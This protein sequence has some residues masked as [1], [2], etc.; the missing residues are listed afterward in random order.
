MTGVIKPTVCDERKLFKGHLS[1]DRRHPALCIGQFSVLD[2]LDG[3]ADFGG[4]LA[5]LAVVKHR[6]F[7][8]IG[9]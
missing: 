6:F 8:L 1:D 3:V 5:D 7:T 9:K 2:A 4:K